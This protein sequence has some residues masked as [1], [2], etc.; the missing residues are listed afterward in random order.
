MTPR[1][2]IALVVIA[3]LFGASV[4][5]S[6]NAAIGDLVRAWGI[7]PSAVGLL[8]NAVQVGFI[9]GTLVFALSGLADRHAA[10]RIFTVCALIAAAANAGFALFAQGVADASV[11]RFI[12]GFA[13]AGVYPLGMKLVVSWRPE[14]AGEALGWLV[15]M[16]TLGTA[17]PHAVRATGSDWRWSAVVGTSSVLALLAAAMVYRLGDGPNL[18]RGA[19]RGRLAWGDALGAFRVPAFR[20]SALGYFGHMWELYA[21]WT[22]TP[23]L[24]D[25]A[26]PDASVPAIAA[27]SFAVIASGTLGCILGGRWSRRIGSARVAAVAL[28]LSGAL[29]LAFPLL[30]AAPAPLV[31]GVLLVWGVAVVADSAQFSALSAR[32]C[33]PALVGS[34]LALQNSIG[35]AITVASIALTTALYDSLGTNVVW[36][37]APGPIL[38]LIGLAPLLRG[39]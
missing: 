25:A 17:L 1:T 15:G 16:L 21:F 7:E 10:S 9:T 3:E 23:F 4:W 29:C 22:L 20:A 6:A 19:G 37:L 18:P 30:A 2:A 13:L 34:A 14:G 26:M 31:I 36:L 27:W 33:P 39:R 32:A 38:G 35:F 5:F 28:A 8:T 24:I 12:T 11:Y